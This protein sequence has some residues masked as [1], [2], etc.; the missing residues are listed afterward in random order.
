MVGAE[1][2]TAPNLYE[3]YR[4]AIAERSLP[5]AIVDLDAVDRNVD[6]L[7]AAV[8]PGDKRIRLASKSI[9]CVELMRHIIDRARGRVRGIMSY[10]VRE[11]CFLVTQGFDD[12]LIAYPTASPTDA[13]LLAD[14]NRSPA[15][16]AIVVDSTDHL[17][18]LDDA[19]REA[20]AKIPV[21][22]EV[23]V[24]YRT[25]RNAIRLGALRSPLH[26]AAAVVDLA[27]RIRDVY[28]N[29]SMHGVMGYEA[30]IAGL[31]DASPYSPL[32][33][34]SKRAVKR[35]SRG[36]V[37]KLREEIRRGLLARGIEYTLFN[38]G[39]TG[40]LHWCA[41][42][43]ALTEVA[44]GSGFLD[45]HLFD[46]YRHLDLEPAAMFAL[47]IVRRPNP[48]IVTCHGGGYVASGEAGVDRLPRPYLPPRVELTRL[49]GAG[50]VQTPL[51]VR[52]GT[53]LRTGDPVFFRHAKAGELAEHFN[54]YLLLRD[55]EVTAE[56]P[57]YR[58]MGQGFL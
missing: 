4:D 22:I 26:T 54:T 35:L 10:A 27:E 11:A 5:V 6:R 37:Q 3:R 13:Q 21:V 20:H 43:D 2:M 56:T 44:A 19:A 38:G 15:T 49:E 23:D 53:K 57:T 42:E 1:T 7:V 30:Q 39:G 25:A 51:S 45:S 12:I 14:V 8:G 28:P 29:L 46:N 50:E 55:K 41:N 34:L 36:P 58:G 48:R 32:L 24:A 16:V 9:R 47:Q 52:A 33:N 40:S 31:Q 18:V 17:E